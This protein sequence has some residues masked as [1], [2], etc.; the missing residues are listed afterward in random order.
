MKLVIWSTTFT[1]SVGGLQRFSAELATG[2]A[3]RGVDVTVLTDTPRGNAG[4]DEGPFRT[5]RG[6]SH[7]EAVRMMRRADV[8]QI[9]GV[10]LR[11]LERAWLAAQRP[12]LTHAG[13]HA[14][15][16][17]G[18]AWSDLGECGAGPILGP[19]AYCP[20]SG[21][22]GRVDV[23]A[24]RVASRFGASNVFVSRYLSDRVGLPGSII[25]NPIPNWLF[26]PGEGERE[27]DLI[28]AA[29]RLVREKGFDRL[30]LAMKEVD[31][32]L[33]VAGAG[34]ERARLGSLVERSDLEGKVTFLGALS[35]EALVDLY[36]RGAI[37][38]V[39]TIMGESFG[40]AVAE[41][42]AVGIPVVGAPTGAI[43]ELLAD[44]RGYVASSA[45]PEAL[46]STIR[47]A[48]VDH[49]GRAERAASAARFAREALHTDVVC[50]KYE[51]LY[52]R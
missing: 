9:A 13:P 35:L 40:Y 37:A 5:L 50:R 48:L 26:G 51:E 36:R 34:P 14:V 3:E 6:A 22:K 28:V 44:G 7:A 18:L 45:T 31:A 17:A 30:L 23:L 27:G 10:S 11:G 19:C 39:P 2:F 8:V 33:V 4:D 29:G 42:M 49:E 52:T 41:A 38:C 43:P 47:E 24:H 25:Y 21:L 1:P 15:C 16:P 12:F 20:S 46:A 32:R